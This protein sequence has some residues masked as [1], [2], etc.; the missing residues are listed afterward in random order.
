LLILDREI[1]NLPWESIPVL[2]N[3]SVCRLPALALLLEKLPNYGSKSQT[4]TQNQPT[5][6]RNQQTR[7]NNFVISDVRFHKIDPNNVFYI[8]NPSQ[9]LATSVSAQGSNPVTLDKCK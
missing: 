2:Q 1:Q 7:K 5:S 4:N 3:Y 6:I 9:D 8:V